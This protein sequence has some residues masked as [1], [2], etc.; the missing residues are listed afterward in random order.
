VRLSADLDDLAACFVTAV[1]VAVPDTPVPD[2]LRSLVDLLLPRVK[3]R[4][5]PE[6]EALLDEAVIAFDAAGARADIGSFA[7][8]VERAAL[9]AGLLLAGKLNVAVEMSGSLPGDDDEADSREREL[10][11]FT[12]SDTAATLRARLGSYE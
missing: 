1:V 5:T 4:I 11:A 9:R 10:Y 12:V 3:Q 7:H 6:D 8:A 2:H